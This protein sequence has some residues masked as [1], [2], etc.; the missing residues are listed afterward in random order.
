MKL[1]I[2]NI[3]ELVQTRN[4]SG[5]VVSG[6]EMAQLPRL[7]NAWLYIENGI[8]HSYGQMSTLSS[9]IPGFYES[10]IY[11]AKGKYLL[12]AWCDSHSHIVFAQWREKEFVDKIRGLSYEQIAQNGGG[13]LNSSARLREMEEQQLYDEALSRVSEV[14][15][16]GTGALEIKSGY[17]LTVNDELKML[18]VIRKLKETT[19]LTIKATFLGAHAVPPEFKGHQGDYVNHVIK[20]MLPLV[21]SENLADYIDVFCDKGFF[22]VD[23]T[24]KILE[25]AQKLGLKPKIHANELDFSGGVQVGVKYNAVSVDHLE[26]SG[27]DEIESL[28][29]SSTIPVLLPNVSFYLNIP[30]APARKM[31]DS[32]LP[33]AL[34]SDYNPGSSPSGNMQFVI[35]LACIKYKM[36]PEEAIN[37]ATINGAYAMEIG[38]THGSISPG[39]VA[40]LILLKDI[41]SLAY[42]PYSFGENKVEKIILNGKLI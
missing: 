18:R 5:G 26:M 4:N 42:L 37:A 15:S 13:I 8:I 31:I 3:K 27:D 41:P 20:D 24:A 10:D 25:A 32:G 38:N 28:K 33:V 39:N 16:F 11:D 17:G 19:P 30:F 21:A 6:N 23:E 29:G 34:A 7:E 12:P 14:I 22:T 40:N 35:S 9:E 2:I 36:F 1:L